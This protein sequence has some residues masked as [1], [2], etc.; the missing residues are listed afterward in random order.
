MLDFDVCERNCGTLCA[1]ERQIVP[2]DNLRHFVKGAILS[3]YPEWHNLNL[4]V[5]VIVFVIAPFLHY[6]FP[7]FLLLYYNNKYSIT[8]FYGS[9]GQ[10]GQFNVYEKMVNL[11]RCQKERLAMEGKK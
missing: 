8:H 10:F 3:N 1:P 2:W 9:A 4:F 7:Y 5:V 6:T 11:I